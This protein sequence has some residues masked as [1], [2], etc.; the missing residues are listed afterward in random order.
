MEI[1]GFIPPRRGKVNKQELTTYDKAFQSALESVLSQLD[2]ES[3]LKLPTSPETISLLT[4]E[5]G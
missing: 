5:R 2:R 1:A 4:A 3:E